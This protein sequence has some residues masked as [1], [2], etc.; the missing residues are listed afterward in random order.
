M[1]LCLHV[2]SCDLSEDADEDPEE[3]AE[4]DVG[5]YSDFGYFRDTIANNLDA[6]RYPT[7]MEHSDCD[8]T[9]SCEEI[10][11]LEHELHE[12]AD[13]FKQLPP[14][15]PVGAFEH[16]S[17]FRHDAASL[18]DCFHNVTGE[19]LFEALLSLCAVAREHQRPIT[20]M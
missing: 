11:L 18:Y 9:W 14:V 6:S 7:L 5:H 2:F 20:F 16:T 3:L 15:E 10:P 12:I 19:N 17:E 1:G 4:C 13:H 8:S